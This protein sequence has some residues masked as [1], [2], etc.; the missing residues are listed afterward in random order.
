MGKQ[1]CRFAICAVV[2]LGTVRL[3]GQE[4]FQ[5][6][7]VKD[8]RSEAYAFLNATIHVDAEMTISTG[9]MLIRDGK[10]EAVGENV[11][12]PDGYQLIELDG[13]HL[14][15]SF[16]DLYSHYGMPAI[17]RPGRSRSRSPEII[18]PK[19]KGPY[20]AN[21]AI[22]SHFRASSIFNLN[23]KAAQG[24]RK[25]GF[26]AVL[27]HQPDGIARGTSALVT[28]G[29]STSNEEVLMEDAAV[30][31]SFKRGSSTQSYP[32][33]MMGYISLLRQ[34]YLD[35]EW[36][37]AQNPRPFVDKSLEGWLS[38]Q[39]LP[40][41][42]EADNWINSLR[43]DKIGDEFGVQ[44]IIKGGGNDYQRI[45]EIKASNAT[46]IVPINFPKAYDVED[47]FDAEKVSLKDMLHWE[48]APTNP[49]ILEANDIPF[50]LTRH[51]LKSDSDFLKN[52]RTAIEQ[53][54]S[55]QMALKA[56]TT[57]PAKLLG[58][59][60]RLGSLRKGMVANFIITDKGL[61]D[62][63]T[64]I[65]ENWI[66]GIPY[67]FEGLTSD[68]FAGKYT[69]SIEGNSMPVEITGKAGKFT[70]KII[71]DDTTKLS[72][73]TT[74]SKEL[75]TMSFALENDDDQRHRLSGWK[76]EQGWAGR[77]QDAMG[78]WFSWTITKDSG[79]NENKARE[80]NKK[81]EDQELGQVVYPFIAFGLQ[82]RPKQEDILIKNVTVWTNEAQGILQN[83]DV[84]IQ[85]SKIKEIGSNLKAKGAKLVDG[86]GKHLTA[87]I[88]DEHTHI[89]GGGNEVLTNSAMVRIGDQINSE[90][91]NIYRGLAGGVTT[92]Q[93]LHG[94]ANPI[95]GQSA[96]IKLRWGATPEELKIAGADEYI[97][98]ALGENVKKSR[99]PE[100][101][102]FPQTRMGVEQVYVDAF[103][104]ALTYQEQ[105][106]KYHSLSDDL[107][108]SVIKPRRNLAHDAILEIL[109][110]ERF[111]TCHSYVQSE[112]NM[113]MHVAERFDFNINTFT[114]IM[115]GY[116]VA[117]KMKAHGVGGS[118]F[119]DWFNY[120]WEVRYA[121]PYNAAIMHNEGVVTAINS[122]D[123]NSG[124]R[125]N[126]EA[127]KS[128][129][130]GNMSEEDALKMVTLNPAKLLHLE[131]RMGSIKVGK[132]AD[133]V[134][135]TDHPLSIYARAEKTIVDGTIY[136]DLENDL[137]RR[138]A[139]QRERARLIQ[140]MIGAKKAG[141]PTQK[142]SSKVD[143]LIYCES[144]LGEENIHEH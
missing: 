20:N 25:I 74:F 53:G 14:Y 42:F 97:K 91:I 52:I 60:D 113:L 46:V 54:L 112:I 131:D 17:K 15:P 18:T 7:D 70:A 127:A 137:N 68:D 75:I 10:I 28:L 50:V 141:R 40:Q 114:H 125:L 57:A 133:V 85:E 3:S 64:K 71:K 123:A 93:V 21:D 115:E 80:E 41:I 23:I 116:K 1:T 62:S 27:T 138:L 69:L 132:D 124:R 78:N 109:N 31:Y 140:K 118:S 5:K 49:G 19:T 22:K 44:Y 66:Q 110:K 37:G 32:Q 13:K 76:K 108:A 88:I 29:E 121:I 48:L 84:L 92:A 43:A 38:F 94:S 89:A 65:Y 55:E 104:N 128:I 33:S 4:T 87:G 45:D 134:L 51:G 111:I 98:F 101:I 63:E 96:I 81:E 11:D 95:G 107:K 82:E 86:T 12:V 139:L 58:A 129:K 119:S 72:T 16:I 30:H 130:Y 35:A 102:R 24:L 6:N 126:Q 79:F 142:A 135:W 61:F 122:D 106:K 103:N 144:V 67:K 99:S 136:F 39:N 120:K 2:V 105:W 90:D 8:E 100:S 73:K 117:D 9:T 26:G 56:L 59:Q 36:Y 34:T 77:G 47:P 83:T 143:M